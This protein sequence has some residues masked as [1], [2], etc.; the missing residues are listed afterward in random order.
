M[1]AGELANRKD[2]ESVPAIRQALAK[3]ADPNE[4]QNLAEALITLGDPEGKAAMAA[5]CADSSVR[6]DSRIIAAS[7]LLDAGDNSGISSAIEILSATEDH[8]VRQGA[9]ELLRRVPAVPS[10]LQP[11][12]QTGLEKALRD[13]V[14]S[15]RVAA[16]ARIAQF[17]LAAADNALRTAIAVESDIATRQQMQLNLQKLESN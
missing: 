3:A 4:R 9:L 5:L 7:Q 14:P 15:N 1:A 13:E 17:K 16:S 2:K 10:N 12:L 6:D 8:S 11:A